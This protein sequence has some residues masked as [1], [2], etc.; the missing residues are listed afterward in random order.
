MPGLNSCCRRGSG[1]KRGG[2]GSRI[3]GVCSSSGGNVGPGGQGR[4]VGKWG[5]M[6]KANA[7]V[8]GSSGEGQEGSGARSGGAR[9]PNWGLWVQI[10][11]A[12][13]RLSCWVF[14]KLS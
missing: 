6:T 7:M 5:A 3:S 1:E 2:A 14:T 11:E 8:V 10:I 13:V 12:G 9:R 4:V